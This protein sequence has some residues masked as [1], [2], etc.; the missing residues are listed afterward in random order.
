[1]SASVASLNNLPDIDFVNKDVDTLLTKMIAD[2]QEAYQSSTGTA[3]T[4][5]SGDPI[6]IWIYAQALRIYSAYQLID[7]AAKYNLLKY[8]SGKYLDHLGALVGVT[9]EAATGASV[10]QQFTLSKKLEA[11][12]T[13][14]AGTRVSTS[15]NIFFATTEEVVVAAGT[16]SASVN[17]ECT[18]TGTA[19]NGYTKGQIN[20]LIDPIQ[21]VAGTANLTTS[22]GGADEEDDDSLKERIFLKPESFSVAGPSGAYEYFVKDYNSAIADVKI[23]GG[24]GNVN[25]YF[26][27][28][29]GELP[30]QTLIDEVTGYLSADTR[31][32]L[33]DHVNVAAPDRVEYSVDM[34]Y[35]ISD[36]DQST[37]S[38]IA[39]AVNK[40]VNDYITWQKSKIGRDINPSKLVAMVMNAGAGRVVV[41][42]PQYTAVGDTEIAIALGD[43]VIKAH[44]ET[45]DE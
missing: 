41:N 40:A 10:T 45:K 39:T 17:A 25:V 24:Q 32:P 31:R 22:Q 14:P 29:N 35:F 4:L 15:D 5:A 1:L 6:R 36:S 44:Q 13:I 43:P 26:I 16:D 37:A 42:S 7:Q 21:F 23:A 9:R 3:K 34:D 28:E 8:S 38:T 18:A 12:V 30:Q 2:Y 19:G 33:T 20:I 27:L 11:D